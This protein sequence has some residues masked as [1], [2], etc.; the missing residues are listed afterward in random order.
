MDQPQSSQQYSPVNRLTGEDLDPSWGSQA[1]SKGQGSYATSR[2]V[3]DNSLVEEAAS[4]KKTSKRRRGSRS[5]TNGLDR[6]KKKATSSSARSESST[7]RPILV[8]MIIDK[9]K[10]TKSGI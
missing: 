2:F 3:E 8:D 6:A 9:W 7:V 5:S 1:Y 4:V 10:G